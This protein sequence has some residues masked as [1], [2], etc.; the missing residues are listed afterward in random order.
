MKLLCLRRSSSVL[1]CALLGLLTIISFLVWLKKIYQFCPK[2]CCDVFNSL[3]WIFQSFCVGSL[4]A[5]DSSLTSWFLYLWCCL[6]HVFILIFAAGFLLNYSCNLKSKKWQISDPEE[7]TWSESS[8]YLCKILILL[9]KRNKNGEI[10]ALG[11]IRGRFIFT[12]H[13]SNIW[14]TIQN[15]VT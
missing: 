1:S 14:I 15:S 7:V 9:Y 12:L 3:S 8:A 2:C 10:T 4:S 13:N 5:S 11:G 6:C